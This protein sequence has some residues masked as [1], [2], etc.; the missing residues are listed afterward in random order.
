MAEDPITFN[1]QPVVWDNPLAPTPHTPEVTHIVTP[2]SNYLSPTPVT[3]AQAL[4]LRK[5]TDDGMTVAEAGQRLGIGRRRAYRILSRFDSEADLVAKSMRISELERME[6]W[7]A[8][9]QVAA[10]KGDHRP[11]KDWLL[12]ARSIEPV[13]DQANQGARIAI[14]IGTPEHPIRVHPPQAVVVG[15]IDP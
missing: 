2:T 11:A 13:A 3:D 5:L 1:G 15:P 6:E 12:H 7:A 10:S 9:C 8:A 4:E 14:I